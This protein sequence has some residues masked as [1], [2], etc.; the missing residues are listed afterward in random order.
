[1][2]TPTAPHSQQAYGTWQ[3]WLLLVA[4]LFAGNAFAQAIPQSTPDLSVSSSDLTMSLLSQIFGDW[5]GSETTSV[6]GTAMAVFNAGILVL[7]SILFIYTA[8][9]G[10]LHSAHDGEVLGKKWSSVWVPARFAGGIFMIF[11]TASGFSIGQIFIMWV[12]AQG[13][14]LGNLVWGSVADSFMSSQGRMVSEKVQQSGSASAAVR[15]IM[16]AELCAAQLRGSNGRPGYDPSAGLVKNYNIGTSNINGLDDQVVY[17]SGS[18]SWGVAD[19]ASLMGDLGVGLDADSVTPTMCGVVVLPSRTMASRYITGDV[20]VAETTMIRAQAEAVEKVSNILRPVADRIV[21]AQSGNGIQSHDA[22]IRKAINDAETAYVNAISVAGSLYLG[23]AN[24]HLT[25]VIQE[26][27]KNGWLTAGM[28]YYQLARINSEL[29]RAV[30]WTPHVEN[31][32]VANGPAGG[33][34]LSPQY[35]QYFD[36]LETQVSR[37]TPGIALNKTG[38]NAFGARQYGA[39]SLLN[40]GT[41]TDKVVS[42]GARMFGFDPENSSHPIIQMKDTGDYIMGISETIAGVGAVSAV[43]KEGVPVAKLASSAVGTIGDLVKKLPWVGKIT[44]WIDLSDGFSFL[45]ILGAMILISMFVFGITLSLYIPM[46]PVILWVGSMVGYF[47]TVFEMMVAVPIWMAAHLHPEG[48]GMAGQFGRQGYVM[49]IEVFARP[50]LMIFGLIG[51]LIVLPPVM[52]VLLGLFVNGAGSM[53]SDSISGIFTWLVL[54]AIYTM[55]CV[56]TMHKLFALI[57]VIPNSVPRWFGAHASGHDKGAETESE[58]KGAVV[59]AI[60]AGRNAGSGAMNQARHR[61]LTET[62][63]LQGGDDKPA[64]GG[65][66]G[67][68][69]KHDNG[70][71]AGNNP[72]GNAGAGAASVG[73]QAANAARKFV[74]GAAAGKKGGDKVDP[75]PST[76]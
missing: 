38:D 35:A 39:A 53:Q 8:T 68:L 72:I 60:M 49:L 64:S 55:I 73:G 25:K 32:T 66:G 26:D 67:N 2:L 16:K 6:M 41:V 34:G 43:L 13:I 5:A 31:I 46:V 29:S 52:T 65:G 1:M 54:I 62:R 21:Q 74:A 56:I 17:S 27:S 14:G 24:N 45:F 37:A 76:S 47:V 71:A 48:E 40:S 42:G 11:P 59:A 33:P 75:D 30:Q 10:T 7:G 19:G 12:A 18:I 15:S 69:G 9:I 63:G 20:S 4:I 58:S 23:A 22:L 50:V 28:W 57:H 51:A 61:Q 70:V 44:K 36:E 3:R